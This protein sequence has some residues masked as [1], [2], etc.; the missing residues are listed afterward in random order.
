MLLSNYLFA[1]KSGATRAY[2]GRGSGSGIGVP[3][4]FYL[5]GGPNHKS[6]AI[7]SSETLVEEFFVGAKI[8]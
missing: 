5:G 1:D 2:H 4:I 6:H 3:R 7:T 8:S